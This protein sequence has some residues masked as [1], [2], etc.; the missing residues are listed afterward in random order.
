M[1]DQGAIS[2]FVL[3]GEHV[4][5]INVDFESPRELR[6]L[7]K[8]IFRSLFHDI[9]KLDFK[10]HHIPSLDRDPWAHHTLH[11]K[12]K[13][14][15]VIGALLMELLTDKHPDGTPKVRQEVDVEKY[16]TQLSE[17]YEDI[18]RA[19]YTIYATY[20]MRATRKRKTSMEDPPQGR[21]RHDDG[22][23]DDG[24]SG[25]DSATARR[26]NS[27]CNANEG[28]SG[29]ALVVTDLDPG[30]QANN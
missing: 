1:S 8:R 20:L 30:P 12:L 4:V 28:D 10:E 22:H 5:T 18:N 13:E 16:Y 11:N 27:G 26:L 14:R 17:E 23:H 15:T 9:S 25:P 7:G 3:H 21:K 6:Q 29:L 19:M 2:T 24:A